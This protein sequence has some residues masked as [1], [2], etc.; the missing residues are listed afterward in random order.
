MPG[1]SADV[2]RRN[3]VFAE[4][5]P[6]SRGGLAADAFLGSAHPFGAAREARA[7]GSGQQAKPA[8]RPALASEPPVPSCVFAVNS[9]RNASLP[10]AATGIFVSAGTRGCAKD[11][12]LTPGES[13]GGEN[14]PC[15]TLP[16]AAFAPQGQSTLSPEA[17][18]LGAGGHGCA[19]R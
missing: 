10:A 11:G 7:V 14:A 17:G 19:R 9:P 5:W 8:E 12:G 13:G 4:T 1:V 15:F 16:S 3:R 6:L 2:S 18:A